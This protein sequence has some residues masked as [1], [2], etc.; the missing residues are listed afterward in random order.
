MPQVG[1]DVTPG[2]FPGAYLRWLAKN[3]PGAG[4]SWQTAEPLVNQVAGYGEG[5]PAGLP[6]Y[7]GDPL[8][9]QAAAPAAAAKGARGLGAL[10]SVMGDVGA[11]KAGEMSIPELIAAHP[12]LVGGLGAFGLGVGSQIGA[13][14]LAGSQFGKT[15]PDAAPA[16]GTIG[17]LAATG[18]GI[19]SFFGPEGT[20]VGGLIG[21]IGGGLKA[22]MS[23]PAKTRADIEN[24]N[25][26]LLAAAGV[27][28]KTLQGVQNEYSVLKQTDPTR[29]AAY[30]NQVYQYAQGQQSLPGLPDASTAATGLNPQTILKLQSQLAG[31]VAPYY[32]QQGKAGDAEIQAMMA[33]A[34]PTGQKISAATQH[35]GDMYKASNDQI[36]QSYILQALGQPSLDALSTSYYNKGVQAATTGSGGGGGSL[37][38]LLL[39]GGGAAGAASGQASPTQS[40]LAT[41]YGGAS[42]LLIQ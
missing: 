17:S 40:A 20:V 19:G 37:A 36:T 29:A 18:A 6:S 9:E 39:S 23:K 15:H 13:K 33:A 7:V 22:L 35:L 25:W 41:N 32:Q 8:I 5:L 11:V 30:L 12:N 28:A 14:A 3:T 24:H 31:I 10:K 1:V 26:Q 16:L 38:S 27:D 4:G 34:T 42:P 21:G 2:E